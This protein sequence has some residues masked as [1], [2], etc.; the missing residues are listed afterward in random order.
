[1]APNGPS[2]QRVIRA[3]LASAGLGSGD[4][5]VV[6]A[7]GTGTRLGDPIEAQAILSTYGQD[8]P[9]SRP[10]LLGSVKSNIAHAQHAAGVAGII[11]MVLAL[12]NDL[13]PA[14]LHADVPSPQVDWSAGAVA[15]L[16]EPV[17]W[18]ANGRPRRAGVSSFGISGTNAHMILEEAPADAEP[19]TGG[20]APPPPV[21]V[22]TEGS[23]WLVSAQ[24]A[25]GLRAQAARLVDCL[26]ARPELGAVDVGWSLAT[27][28]S[29]FEHRAVITGGG[30]DELLGGLSALA[31]GS[32]AAG[33]VTGSAGGAGSPVFVFP[34]QGSQ[35]VGMG[36]ELL[37]SSPVFAARLAECAQ[38]LAPYVDWSLVDV[39]AGREG[40]PGFDRVDVVQPVLWAVMVSLAA[41]WEAAGVEPDAVLGHSQGEI[42]AAVVAGILSLEDAARVVALRSRALLAL[43]GRGGMVSIAEP[44]EAVVARLARWGD[45]VSVAAVNGPGATVV[46]GDLDALAQ[47]LAGCEGDEVRAR[48]LPVDYASHGSQV[49]A[50]REEILAVLADIDPRPGRLPMVSAMT[51]E[52]VAGPELDAGYWYAS[53]RSTVQFARATEALGRAGYGVFIETSA[54]PVLTTAIGETLESLGSD[55]RA[56][57]VTGTL[58]RDDGGP[59][60]LLAALAEAHVHGLQVNWAAVLP[61]GRRVNLPTYAFQRQ[62]YWPKSPATTHRHGSGA[63]SAGE[64]AFWTAV[65]SGDIQSLSDTLAVDSERLREVLPALTAW[66]TRERSQSAAAD[67]RYRITWTPLAPLARATLSGTWLVVTPEG[68]AHSELANDCRRALTEHGAQVL[69]TEVPTGD[70]DRATLAD[71]ITQTLAEHGDGLAVAGIVSL[72]ATD[73]TPLEQSPIVPRGLAATMSLVQALGDTDISAPLW[74]LTEAAITAAAGDI[75]S[76]PVAAQSW[77]FGRVAALEHPNRWGGLIDLPTAWDTHTAHHLATVLAGCG[78]DQVAIRPAAVLGRRLIRASA[79]VP[80]RRRWTPAGTV[81]ITGGTGGVGTHIARWLTRRD[82]TSVALTSRSGP[83]A[84]GAAALAAEVATAGTNVAVLAADISN[85]TQA[86]GLLNWI[87]THG[88]ALSSILHAAGA[89]SDT[90]V[91]DM[92][93]A[94]LTATSSAK[95]AGATNLDQLTTGHNLDAFVM[96]SSGAGTWGSTRLAGYAAANAALDALV[97]NRRARG[98]PGTSIAWGLWGGGGMGDGAAGQTLQRLGVR[99]MDPRAATSALGAVLDAGEAL[100]AVSDIDWERFTPVFT[101]Q[102]P[103]PLLADR[104]EAQQAL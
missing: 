102:R 20:D 88:P 38:A 95:L 42:A 17:A 31:G 11:K 56:P 90:P 14:T 24:S 12:R 49:D 32:P 28:R 29:V 22:L 69:L 13:L 3:A 82:S 55:D 65:T 19:E 30:R 54:H 74:V 68:P 36:R 103:S 97:E 98:L 87:D 18:K 21:S 15:L 35:W 89:G 75:A 8:R 58:R 43:S 73:I 45:R 51:G 99:E 23:A 41:V 62:R 76:N 85:P 61:R 53:L 4:V 79:P 83:S 66:R 5:D 77:A 80:G 67:W 26:S 96:F 47:V 6:E 46:S 25:A 27:T 104:P 101:V 59:A 40:A 1:S 94:E 86:A 44:V 71:R 64:N 60:R 48:M 2:Q 100:V 57:V 91:E 33:L 34:G 93:T 7:H 50:L 52:F 92:T 84:T 10:V 9:E 16:T 63:T 70:I 37:G 72:L 78:E 81:L 39:V